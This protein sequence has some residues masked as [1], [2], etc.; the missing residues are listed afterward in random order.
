MR[1]AKELKTARLPNGKTLKLPQNISD[2][3]IDR[4][5]KF[6]LGKQEL[7]KQDPVIVN[8]PEPIDYTSV[9]AEVVKRLEKLSK[10]SN[11]I[12]EI[13]VEYNADI[14]KEVQ[15]L[16]QSIGMLAT[17]IDKQTT[18]IVKAMTMQSNVLAELVVAYREP[19]KITRDNHGRPEGIE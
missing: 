1:R 7:P 15:A 18:E 2:G 4:L 17:K 19:K 13:K 12:P 14:L 5:V 3:E 6:L 9:F 10:K 11:D 8:V 16:N